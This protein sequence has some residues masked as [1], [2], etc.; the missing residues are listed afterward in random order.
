MTLCLWT[1]LKW[2]ANFLKKRKEKTTQNSILQLQDLQ[3]DQ[4]PK[5]MEN[6]RK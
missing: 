5:Y 4:L 2:K 6:L 3:T 1:A